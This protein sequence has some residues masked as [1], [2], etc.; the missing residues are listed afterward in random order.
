VVK[1]SA[2]GPLLLKPGFLVNWGSIISTGFYSWNGIVRHWRYSEGEGVEK[3]GPGLRKKKLE[4]PNII[5]KA[6]LRYRKTVEP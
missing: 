5:E 3:T 2:E 1:R 4:K 6:F